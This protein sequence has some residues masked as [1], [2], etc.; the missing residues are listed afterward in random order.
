MSLFKVSDK[1]NILGYCL[2]VMSKDVVKV[3]N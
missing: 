3:K 2:Q 1:G